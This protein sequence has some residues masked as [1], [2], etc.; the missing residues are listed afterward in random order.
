MSDHK[1]ADAT[2]VAQPPAKTGGSMLGK[3]VIALFM[4]AVI[5]AIMFSGFAL[6]VTLH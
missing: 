1:N 2:A 5:V 6:V 4:G 3:L